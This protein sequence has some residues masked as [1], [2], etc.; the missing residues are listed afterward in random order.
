MTKVFQMVGVLGFMGIVISTAAVAT[1]VQG[2]RRVC[3]RS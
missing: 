1:A 2:V 3:S